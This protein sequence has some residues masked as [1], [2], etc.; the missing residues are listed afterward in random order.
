MTPDGVVL[1]VRDRLICIKVSPAPECPPVRFGHT[2]IPAEPSI[3]LF[4]ASPDALPGQEDP[5]QVRILMYIFRMKT[6]V[7]W[8]THRF[9]NKEVEV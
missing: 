5:E 2:Y 8:R 6:P 3:R 9:V 1:S 4:P 7:P